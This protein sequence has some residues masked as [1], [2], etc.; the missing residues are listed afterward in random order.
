MQY[1]ILIIIGVLLNVALIVI[2]RFIVKIPDK[3]EIALCALGIV[4][5]LAGLS[6]SRTG[7]A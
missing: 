7:A 6:L 4:L 2:N 3:L 1:H 5:M